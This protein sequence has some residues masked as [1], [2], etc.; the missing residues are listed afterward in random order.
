LKI[1]D[2]LQL[3]ENSTK[4][5][6]RLIPLPDMKKSW[7]VRRYTGNLHEP[8]VPDRIQQSVYL[9]GD[10]PA[11]KLHIPYHFVI[12]NTGKKLLKEQ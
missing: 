12:V 7:S 6:Y 11:F 9:F 2:P 4:F 5:S 1:A 3:Y 8:L 10:L